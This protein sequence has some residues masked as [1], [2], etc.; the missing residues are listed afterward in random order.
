MFIIIIV[1]INRYLYVCNVCVCEQIVYKVLK[2]YF[3]NVKTKKYTR[4][5]YDVKKCLI[6][7]P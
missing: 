1:L 2:T 5:T 6:E 4:E 3:I 7:M